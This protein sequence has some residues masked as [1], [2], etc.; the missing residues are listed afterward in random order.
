VE[1][2]QCKGKRREEGA[3]RSNQA[4]MLVLLRATTRALEGHYRWT[5]LPRG[6]PTVACSSNRAESGFVNG[7]PTFAAGKRIFERRT[8]ARRSDCVEE[9]L[10]WSC[11]RV[12]WTTVVV[13]NA[14]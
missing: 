14:A 13:W 8:V 4:T 2:R 3:R 7:A 5:E 11:V 1:G 9:R 12:E 6:G 10:W